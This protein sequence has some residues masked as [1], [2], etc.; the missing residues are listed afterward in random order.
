[1]EL[2]EDEPSRSPVTPNY[3]PGNEVDPETEL[4]KF[5]EEIGDGEI[6]PWLIFEHCRKKL[7]EAEGLHNNDL[8][9]AR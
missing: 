9:R 7:C 5:L 3:F 1:M 6:E 8:F 4:K 2:I